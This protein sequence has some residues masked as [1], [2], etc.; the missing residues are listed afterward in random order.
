MEHTQS[1]DRGNKFKLNK[2]A[3]ENKDIQRPPA[4]LRKDIK[5]YLHPM[6]HDVV[7]HQFKK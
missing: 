5:S 7:R 3:P 1:M 6:M 4:R 2:L